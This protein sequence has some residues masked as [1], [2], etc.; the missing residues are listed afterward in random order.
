LFW[1]DGRASARSHY[2]CGY[3]FVEKIFRDPRV[4]R[5][6]KVPLFPLRTVLYP[7]GPLPL[8]IF[9]PRY[10]DMISTCLKTDSSFGVLLIRDGTEAGPATTHSVGTLAR[11]EDW[12]QGSDGLLGITAIGEDKFRLLSSERQAN[13]LNLGDIECFGAEPIQELPEGDKPLAHILAG[14]LDD[15]GKLYQTLDKNYDDAGW[16]AYRFAEILPISPKQKQFCL[17]TED[18][19]HRLRMMREVLK[20]VRGPDALVIA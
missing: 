7:G 20:T 10:L 1:V 19:L 15:L 5:L 4:G 9:E 3:A 12:Y 11:I 13:G 16:V 18:P 14:V 6:M 8:R 17:E 2:T